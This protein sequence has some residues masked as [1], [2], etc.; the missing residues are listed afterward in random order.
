MKSIAI[1]LVNI[2]KD[3]L[4]SG[5]KKSVFK[6]FLNVKKERFKALRG[7][8]LEIEKG[9]KVG[10]LGPNGGGKTTLMKVIS[11]ISKPSAGKVF[12]EGK[13]VSLTNLDAGFHP[14]LTGKENIYI[15][16]L[17]AGMTRQQIQKEIDSIIQF[18]GIEEFINAPFFTYSAGM[19]FRLA[20][21]IAIASK[22]DI[23]L[24][25]EVFVAGDADFQKKTFKTIRTLQKETHITT[26][27]TSH[28]AVLLLA[29]SDTF[30][31][32]EKGEIRKISRN[33]I[34]KIYKEQ[35]SMWR[36]RT[37]FK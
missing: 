28:L 26:I 29:F 20:F 25:D 10:I 6:K 3:Y 35:D 2:E 18:S 22:C 24:M 5:T 27:M 32:L 23:L 8:N 17:L 19:K 4:V 34:I 30:Y 16:G 12:A 11:G 36:M 14:D 15:N 9:K 21:S 13:I 33:E 31:Y 7:I 37:K 1:K